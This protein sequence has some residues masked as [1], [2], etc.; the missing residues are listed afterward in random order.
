MAL[1]PD[2]DN[3]NT[4]RSVLGFGANDRPSVT[5]P[6]S[7]DNPTEQQWFNTSAFV[8][9][10]RGTFGNAGR[11]VVYG[12]GLGVVNAS[13]VKTTQVT[14]RLGVQFRVEAFNMLNRVNY[15]LPDNYLG[16]PTFG[17]ILSAGSPRRIQLGLKLLF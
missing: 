5:G 16:S 8:I 11:N 10:P 15:D 7:L 14:E 9:P 3:S 4:G 13:L 17:A 6:V 2:N 12:P 1:L